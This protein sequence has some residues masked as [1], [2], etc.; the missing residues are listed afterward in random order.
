MPAVPAR[1]PAR[2]ASGAPADDRHVFSWS[3]SS[4]PNRAS[5]MRCPLRTAAPHSGARCAQ[6]ISRDSL[7]LG[8]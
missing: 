3:A 5:G 8:R 6:C 1:L 2:P 7:I 4:C